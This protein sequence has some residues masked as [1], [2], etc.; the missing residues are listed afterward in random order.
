M[1]SSAIQVIKNSCHLSVSLNLRLS[2][3]KL[4]NKIIIIFPLI[5]KIVEIGSYWGKKRLREA[6]VKSIFYG[7]VTYFSHGKGYIT[8]CYSYDALPKV[9]IVYRGP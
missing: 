5:R 8:S 1:T 2:R 4:I 3:I 9:E 7:V 6:H